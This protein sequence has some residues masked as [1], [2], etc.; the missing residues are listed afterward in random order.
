M[1]MQ[2][3]SQPSIL[4]AFGLVALLLAG[5]ATAQRSDSQISRAPFGRT[6]DGEPVDIYTLR[7]SQ[8]AEARIMTYGG[9]V[10]SLKV[11]DRSGQM[12]DVVLGYERLA[13]YIADNPYFGCLVGRYGNRI[14]NGSFTLD[15]QTHT[16]A[17]NNGPNHLHGGLKGFDK[18][19]WRARAFSSP[20]G[21]ALELNYLSPNGEEGYPGNLNVTAVYTLTEDNAL[22][23]DFAAVT[24]RPT[25]VNLTHHSYFNLAGRGDI[26]GH[27]VM[28]NA[29]RF[30]PV[31]ETLIPIGELR[32]VE[33]TPFDFRT[34]TPIGAR[35]DR[36]DTQLRF[37]GG[38]DH[39][40]VIS[41]PYGEFGLQARVY[42][43]TSGR[44]MEVHS[45]EPGLQFY[46]GNFLDGTLTGKGGWVYEHRHGFCM[47][48]QHYP[49]SPNQP[50]FPSTVL[51][52]GDTYRNTIV[53]RFLT[54]N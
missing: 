47:E 23:L 11:P 16:L 40:W 48:P 50:N 29:D 31:D 14:A 28:I 42:E 52:P 6:P 20:L 43:P 30:T 49:D 27:E 17:Q 18:V 44:V 22:R 19:V 25:V 39:N 38:Y 8:G 3:I 53:Y 46:S 15:G 10:V 13:D 37:G 12:G 41:K 21:P 33:G 2:S 1:I 35:I 36:D 9:I 32:P 4:L 51:R 34:S 7:N 54:Q 45:T 5:C 24:D 26:L